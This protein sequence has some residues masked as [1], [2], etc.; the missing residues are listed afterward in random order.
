[1]RTGRF[2]F[3]RATPLLIVALAAMLLIF[4]RSDN[5]AEAT[6]FDPHF[7][8]S[9]SDS[10]PG[11]NADISITF[12]VDAPDGFVNVTNAPT[13]VFVPK[14]WDIN[15]DAP[16]GAIG[17]SFNALATLGIL[18]IT[19]CSFGIT[20]NPAMYV[21]SV[22]PSNPASALDLPGHPGGPAYSGQFVPDPENPDGLYGGI[23]RY[24]DFLDEM[25]PSAEIGPPL[26]R[27]WGGQNVLL[28]AISMNIVTFAPGQL[29]GYPVSMGYPTVTILLDPV[30]PIDLLMLTITS[31]LCTPLNLLNTNFGVSQDNP[32]TAADEGGVPLL[33]NPS[34]QSEPHTFTM[35]T[36]AQPDADDDG[37]ENWVDTCAFAPNTEDVDGRHSDADDDGLDGACDPDPL[38]PSPGSPDLD[39]PDE[40]LDNYANRADNC[41]LDANGIGMDPN[42]IQLLQVG[43]FVF[44]FAEYTDLIGP[45]NQADADGD[46]IGDSCEGAELGAQCA[47][48]LDDDFDG[49][50]NDGCPNF[51]TPNNES[52]AQCANDLDDD[53]D[54]KV[55]D[56]CPSVGTRAE[57]PIVQ[58]IR[59]YLHPDSIIQSSNW[60]SYTKEKAFDGL[61]NTS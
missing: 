59:E 3:M 34:G 58:T 4:A 47:N 22:D 32:N 45:N 9:V 17:G 49:K 16:I 23:T 26:V 36:E 20:F 19:P 7:S 12:S 13:I 43:E 24:P 57:S 5:P 54:G 50:V 2:S 6:S 46:R 44:P 28:A 38:N 56:G 25:S 53:F 55:N 10:T 11:A 51:P 40:D 33:T 61:T 48:D 42:S 52:G 30:A 60:P 1:M 37:I 41:P 14:Q 8:A 35:V 21:A 27:L 18:G 39:L 31:D 29:P 15:A